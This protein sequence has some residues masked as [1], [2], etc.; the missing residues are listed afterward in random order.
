MEGGKPWDPLVV[1]ILD[2]LAGREGE[3]EALYSLWQFHV[4]L[5]NYI[6]L[7]DAKVITHH[8]TIA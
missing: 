8:H 7:P 4:V 3:V 5:Y 1:R 6:S 2:S